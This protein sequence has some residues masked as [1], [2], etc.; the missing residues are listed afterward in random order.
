MKSTLTRWTTATLSRV[1]ASRAT[2]SRQGRRVEGGSPFH[3]RCALASQPVRVTESSSNFDSSRLRLRLFRNCHLDHAIASVGLDLIAF[4]AVRRMGSQSRA[5]PVRD[6]LT[7]AAAAS[8]AR[9]IEISARN[10]RGPIP[11]I[12]KRDQRRALYAESRALL[13]KSNHSRRRRPD[14]APELNC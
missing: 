8:D 6:R 11:V 3:C 14:L 12:G 5:S 4:D 7:I 2:A 9:A 10:K 13:R 1:G